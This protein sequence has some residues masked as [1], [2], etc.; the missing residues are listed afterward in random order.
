[1]AKKIIILTSIILVYTLYNYH[2]NKGFPLLIMF[3][4]FCI[5]AFSIS[6]IYS[7]S[8]NLEEETFDDVEK[9]INKIHQNNGIFEYKNEGFYLKQKVSTDFI[10]WNDIESITYFNINMLKNIN[11]NGI[12]VVTNKKIYKIHNNNEQTMGIEKFKDEM[13]K[14]IIIRDIYESEILSD[15]SYRTPLFIKVPN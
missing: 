13:N 3:I 14:N 5:I 11:Q 2:V 9:N 12:E 6:K 15:G 1:M 8:E 10:K 4:C 7:D